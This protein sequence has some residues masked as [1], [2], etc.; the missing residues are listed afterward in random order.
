[1]F[2]LPIYYTQ[3]QENFQPVKYSTFHH[4]EITLANGWVSTVEKTLLN[5]P[6]KETCK[7]AEP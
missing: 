7:V 4:D 3:L 5:S 2:Y 6:A 1:M